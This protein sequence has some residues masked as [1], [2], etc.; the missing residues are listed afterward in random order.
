MRRGLEGWGRWCVRSSPSYRSTHVLT[1]ARNEGSFRSQ[2]S[3]GL[4]LFFDALL[5]RG[6]LGT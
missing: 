4:S 5:L 1:I 6:I 3:V 2:T